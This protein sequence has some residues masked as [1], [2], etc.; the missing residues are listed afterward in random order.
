[1]LVRDDLQKFKPDD[2]FVYNLL[3][4]FNVRLAIDVGAHKGFYSKAIKDRCPLSDVIAVEAFPGNYE[5]F[6]SYAGK[7]PGVEL[8]RAGA[9]KC[10][11]FFR[12]FQ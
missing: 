3:P 7:I 8:V 9:G 12:F 5:A 2:L 4:K 10:G 11:G 1:M 6:D